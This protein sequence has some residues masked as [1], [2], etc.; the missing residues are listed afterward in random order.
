MTP[1]ASESDEGSE[2]GSTGTRSAKPGAIV[3]AAKR[4]FLTQGYAATS[5]DAVARDAPVSKRTLYNHFPS[6]EALFAAVVQDAYASFAPPAPEPRAAE[7]PREALRAYVERMRGH[8]KHPDV[9]PLLKLIVA[10]GATAPGLID[11]YLAA[12]KGPAVTELARL[13]DGVPD[14]LGMP[15]ERRALQFLGMVKEGLFW[16][17]VLGIPSGREPET[18]IEDAIDRILGA[19]RA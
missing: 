11:S 1:K 10:E 18:V 9:L 13:L 15:A 16:P 3:A 14:P 8:W 12:G 6:K 19:R 2:T 17:N 4:L 5:M 7:E